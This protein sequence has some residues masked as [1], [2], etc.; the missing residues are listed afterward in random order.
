MEHRYDSAI[1]SFA[2]LLVAISFITIFLTATLCSNKTQYNKPHEVPTNQQ[3]VEVH[4]R[5][6]QHFDNFRRANQT[7]TNNK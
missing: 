3:A 1:A 6:A 7:S 4:E 5:K 2:S